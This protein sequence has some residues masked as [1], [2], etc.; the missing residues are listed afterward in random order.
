MMNLSSKSK[1]NILQWNA[2]S[3][4]ANKSSLEKILFEKNI[5]IAIISETWFKPGKF[6]NFPGYNIIR[7]DRE[8]GRAGV[9]LFIKN[10]IF[11][12]VNNTY[13]QIPYLQSCAVEIMYNDKPLNIIS[14]YNPPSNN[15]TSRQWQQF[16]ASFS[17]SSILGGDANCHHQV[18]GCSITDT[19]GRSLQDAVDDSNFCMLN[20]GEPTLV[21]SIHHRNSSAIDITLVTPDLF[22]LLEWHL[23][24][25]SHGSNHFPILISSQVISVESVLK[26]PIRKWKIKQADWKIFKN[27]IEVLTGK[28]YAENNLSYTTFLDNL[29]TACEKSI[30][31]ATAFNENQKFRR[32]WWNKKVE[33]LLLT[34]K[35]NL[36][37]YKQNPTT[38][39]FLQYTKSDANFKR[40]CKKSRKEAWENF[41]NTLNRQQKI[42]EVWKSIKILKNKRSG[43]SPPIKEGEWSEIFFNNLCPPYIMQDIPAFIQEGYNQD[44]DIIN[45]NFSMQELEKCIKANSNSAPG[46]DNVHYSMLNNLP[47]LSKEYLL[48]IFN[49]IWNTGKIPEDWRS[50]IIVPFLKNGK[51]PENE[52]SYRPISLASCVLKTFER[53]VKYRLDWWLENNEILPPSQHGFRKN[54]SVVEA[55]ASLLLDVEQGLAD[56]KSTLAIL[57]DVEGAYNCIQI[58]ILMEKLK[59][60][61]LPFKLIRIIYDIISHRY[62]F[63]RINNKLIGPRMSCLGLGQGDI[64]S[65]PL[66]SLFT[67]DL[68]S[69]IPSNIKI[70]QF[71]D[72]CTI[73]V[74]E[75]TPEQCE[76]KIKDGIRAME[77]YMSINGMKIAYTKCEGIL[78]SRKRRPN[79]SQF[80]SVDNYCE[81][82]VNKKVRFLGL[83]LEEKL[84]WT[85]HIENIINKSTKYINILK[86]VCNKHWGM[87]P[88]IGLTF[89]RAT[90]RAVLDFG[91]IFYVNSARTKLNKVHIIQY[92]AIRLVMGYLNSTPIDVILQEAREK[93]ISERALLLMDRFV[94]KNLASRNYVASQLNSYTIMHLTLNKLKN[95]KTPPL[96]ESYCNISTHY[97]TQIHNSAILPLYTYSYETLLTKI[98]I[99]NLNLYEDAPIPFKENMLQCE[100]KEKWPD[101]YLL[102]TDGS[103][104]GDAVGAAF[105]D[106]QVDSGE[107]YKIHKIATIYTAESFAILQALKYC[108]TLTNTDISI[109]SDSKSCI[110]NLKNIKNNCNPTHLTLDIHTE[111]ARLLSSGK[112]VRLVWI[113]GHAGLSGNEAADKLAKQATHSDTL[114]SYPIPAQDVRAILD[115]K[116]ETAWRLTISSKEN[117][118][119]LFY[120]DKFNPLQKK[121][122]FSDRHN[123]LPCR[124]FIVTFNRIRS[125]HGICK[126]YLHKI[127]V[128]PTNLCEICNTKEDFEHLIMCCPKYSQKRETIFK[129]IVEGKFLDLPFCYS[130]LVQSPRCYKLLYSFLLHSG[131]TP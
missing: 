127:N 63:L 5:H 114:M 59:R 21:R 64:L 48:Y 49:E 119:G 87:D 107:M 76:A 67:I 36:N 32:P 104:T 37:T 40:Q 69:S 84:N 10:N 62:L 75:K 35:Q 96:V 92:R 99:E 85:P 12:S 130:S 61:N 15:L 129:K 115:K 20:T 38:E 43:S 22:G 123:I 66:Y 31:K 57:Y 103:K 17:G 122:W 28:S 34:R 13:Y 82:P 95:K 72:D 30:P 93:T 39:N 86:S 50:I 16:F 14:F 102:F 131:I 112:A 90:V 74:T 120:K 41:C 33:Q 27:E 68:E 11:Y 70:I 88:H 128:S 4:I 106:P 51:P 47:L 2:R 117:N 126:A 26:Q 44:N 110:E 73:Y 65:C 3:A 29:D 89:Y 23:D 121:T 116:H 97:T 53:L 19:K 113:R 58:P 111:Y 91:S 125:N 52:K 18:W 54:R 94:L 1:L 56:Q 108:N 24:E 8:D 7:E 101:T 105:Y 9:A 45:S 98:N 109:L 83:I 81:I 118:K 124:K 46:I 60:L 78:F 80:I 25:D 71:V 77:N 42:S 55:Q 100:I 6:V 79:I